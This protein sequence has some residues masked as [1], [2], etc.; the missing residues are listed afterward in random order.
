MTSRFMASAVALFALVSGCVAG[1]TSSRHVAGGD[2]WF[3]EFILGYWHGVIAW[4]TL[5]LRFID[6]LFPGGIPGS[7]HMYETYDTG[8]FY[9]LGFLLGVY[10]L[11]PIVITVYPRTWWI[12]RY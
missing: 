8:A 5:I 10:S 4:V 6:Q 9:G 12:R 1:Q 11:V 7:W 2:N 3:L